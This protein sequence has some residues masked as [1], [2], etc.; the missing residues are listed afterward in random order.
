[1]SSAPGIASRLDEPPDPESFRQHF[2]AP[3][4]RA[5]Q[6]SK[7]S[8]SAPDQPPHQRLPISEPKPIFYDYIVRPCRSTLEDR[9]DS[10]VL[11]S[12]SL[13][14]PNSTETELAERSTSRIDE[15]LTSITVLE[16][17]DSADG[18]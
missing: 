6:V 10:P 13:D 4:L 15:P 12:D 3:R 1:M 14:S 2:L 7:A 5:Q 8:F 18:C 9:G 17:L 11:A 16:A